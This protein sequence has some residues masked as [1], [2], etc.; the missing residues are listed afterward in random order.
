MGIT[1]KVGYLEYY[2]IAPIPMMRAMS[3][4]LFLYVKKF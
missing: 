1:A 2:E 3:A 4:K